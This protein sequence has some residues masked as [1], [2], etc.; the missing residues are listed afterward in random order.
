M[1]KKP[2]GLHNDSKTTFAFFGLPDI[3]S[4]RMGK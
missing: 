4:D 2:N 1:V 3:P